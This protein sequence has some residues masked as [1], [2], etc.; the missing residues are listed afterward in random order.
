[1]DPADA[2]FSVASLLN[3]LDRCDDPHHLLDFAVRALSPHGTLVLATV[4]PF[5]AAVFE[6]KVGSKW[7][8]GSKRRPTDPFKMEVASSKSFETNAVSFLDT[9]NREHPQLELVTW[10]RLPY[11]SSGD[12]IKTHYV[13]DMA[14]M[15]F[16]VDPSIAAP[17]PPQ[18]LPT[19]ASDSSIAAPH[20]P[21]ANAVAACGSRKDDAIYAWL[22][23]SLIQQNVSSWESVLDAGTGFGSMCWLMRQKRKTIT[24]VTAASTG[25]YGSNDLSSAFKKEDAITIAAGNWKDAS[26]LQNETFD[27]VV[28]DYLLGAVELHWPHGA[29]GMMDRVLGATSPGGFVLIV[30]LEPYEMVLNRARYKDR[31]VLDIEAIG[32]SAAF[33]A[34]K[35]TYREVP[36]SWVLRQVG[37]FPDFQVVATRQFEMRIHARSLQKQIGYARSTAKKIGDIGMKNAYLSRVTELEEELRA[38]KGPHSKGARNYAIVLHRSR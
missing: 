7:G 29:D 23:S 25:T 33:V 32:E 6:G 26:F 9:I 35:T 22:A 2:D 20:D 31:L 11:V 10:S 37:R 16:R 17:T 12:H 27:V 3:V 30:G 13:L 1:L 4:L 14:L 28:A 15:V 21:P 8:K 5:Q 36:E 34:G 24:G 19:A 18:H 38:Y